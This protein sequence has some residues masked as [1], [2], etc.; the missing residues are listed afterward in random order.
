MIILG[1]GGEMTTMIPETSRLRARTF[2]L[3]C[4][5]AGQARWRECCEPGPRV[6]WANR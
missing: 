3:P 2:I 4:T 1:L 6:L 5:R